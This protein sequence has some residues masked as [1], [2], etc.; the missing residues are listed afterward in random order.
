[1]IVLIKGRVDFVMA[2]KM[3]DLNATLKELKRRKSDT[4]SL[5]RDVKNILSDL[6]ETYRSVKKK[7]VN[8]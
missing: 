4:I 3:R 2:S 7:I 1:M 8:A 6:R 5:M